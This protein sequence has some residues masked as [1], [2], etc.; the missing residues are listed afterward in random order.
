MGAYNGLERANWFAKV[1]TRPRKRPK[2]GAAKGLGLPWEP[3][4]RILYEYDHHTYRSTVAPIN[5]D[6]VP[7][8]E[9]KLS[10]DGFI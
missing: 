8:I 4:A 7:Q 10:N 5:V 1:M 2:P 3:K 9:V 6:G